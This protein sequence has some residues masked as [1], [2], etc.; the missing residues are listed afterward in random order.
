MVLAAGT[1]RQFIHHSLTHGLVMFF[2][3][4]NSLILICISLI[5]TTQYEVEITTI[6]KEY[7]IKIILF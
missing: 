3:H 4:L 2:Y 6:V 5:P 7:I 1:A